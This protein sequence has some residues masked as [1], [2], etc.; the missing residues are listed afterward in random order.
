MLAHPYSPSDFMCTPATNVKKDDGCVAERFLTRDFIGPV[1]TNMLVVDQAQRIIPHPLLPD[2]GSELESAWEQG[3]VKA[4][5]GSD[6]AFERPWR[7]L[8]GGDGKTPILF[9]NS[10]V[11]GSGE[12]FIEQPLAFNGAFASWFPGAV[13]GAL[14]IGNDAPLSAVV[15][16]SARFTYVSPAGTLDV[17]DNVTES[18][19][20]QLVDGGYFENSGTA[21][22]EGVVKM[23]MTPTSGDDRFVL[24]HKNI[25]VIHISND[26]A[27]PSFLDDGSDGCNAVA[28]TKQ[29]A[30]PEATPHYGEIAAPVFALLDTRDARGEVAR[31]SIKSTLCKDHIFHFRLCEGAHHLPLGW[32]LSEAAWAELDRQLDSPTASTDDTAN[33]IANQAQLKKIASL[34]EMLTDQSGC[35]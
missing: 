17:P 8:S 31:R 19:P 3:W 32:T 25:Y 26:P 29:T 20:L 23:L 6:H 16:N 21:T 34:S 5:Q 22:L 18:A 4:T 9:L 33:M 27:V 30:A 13:D 28:A 2:R 12:R 1:L 10:T 15:H 7:E 14:W 24:P 35:P 11:V